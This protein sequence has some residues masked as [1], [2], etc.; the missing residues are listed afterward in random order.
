MVPNNSALNFRATPT[1]R[2]TVEHSSFTTDAA[3]PPQLQI[4]SLP[5]GTSLAK[6]KGYVYDSSAGND[7]NIYVIDSGLSPSNPVSTHVLSASTTNT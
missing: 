5:K 7:I 3:A 2:D 4:I 1:R 6:S